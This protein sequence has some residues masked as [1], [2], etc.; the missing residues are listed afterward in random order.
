MKTSARI[1]SALVLA[2]LVALVTTSCSP[3][4]RKAKFLERADRYFTNGQFDQAEIEYKNALAI[5]ALNPVAISR[6]GVIYFEQGR[7]ARCTPYLL[8]GRELRPDDLE[9]RLKLAQLQLGA[10]NAT[11]AR[12]EIDFI[13]SR[14]PTQ[15]EALLLLA[16]MGNTQ[17]QIDEIRQRLQKIAG[18]NESAPLLVA[19]GML[20]L[21]QRNLP[22]AQAAFQK[23][24]TLDP[25]SSAA[26]AALGT[27]YWAQGNLPEADQAL[28]KSAELSPPRSSR[29]LAYAQFKLQTGDPSAARRVLEELT[30]KT[31]DYL[32]AWLALAEMA[33]RERKYDDSLA[34]IAKILVRDDIMPEALLLSSRLRLLKGENDKAVGEL[35]KML[36]IYP[37]AYEVHYQ[38]GLAYLATGSKEKAIASL[39]Q[40]VALAPGY[41]EAVVALANLRTGGGDPIAAV[42]SLKQYLQQHP[43]AAQAWLS[44]AEA[45]RAQGNPDDALGAY[46]ELEKRFPRNPQGPFLTGLMLRQQN[47]NDEARQA[48]NRAIGLAPGYLPAVEQLVDLDLAESHYATAH[49][50]I[51]GLLAANPKLAEAYLLRARI[52]LTQ[53]DRDQAE[54]TLRKTIEL[55]PSLPTSYFLLARLY[56]TAN[57]QAKALASLLQAVAQNPRDVTAKM[58]V[59][60][61]YEQRQDFPAAQKAYEEILGIN[62]GFSPALNNLAYLYSE[63]TSQLDKAYTLAQ[64]ARELLPQDPRAADT[65]GWILFKRGE[66]RRALSLLTESA[67][68]LPTNAEIQFHLG[69]THYMMGEETSARLALDRALQLSKDFPQADEARRRLAILEIDVTKAGNEA[70]AALEKELASRKDDPMVLARLASVY[71][72][73]GVV[74]KAIGAYQ[75]ALQANPANAKI[76]LNLVRIYA[77]RQDNTKAMELAKTARKAAP[78]NPNVAHVLGRL[79]YQSGDY[80]WGAS[81][82]QEAAGKLPNDPEVLYDFARACYSVGRVP[83][84]ET[85]LR[86]AL[87]TGPAFSCLDDAKRFLDMLDCAANPTQASAA[88]KVEQALKANPED[89]P[90]LMAKAALAEH[91]TDPLA[92]RAIYEK[93]LDY[94]KEFSPAKRRLAILLAESSSDERKALEW[95]RQARTA[96]PNDPELAKALGILLYK[97]KDYT[98][99]VNLLKESSRQR[100]SDASLMYYL[101]MAQYGL[102]DRTSAKTSLQRSLDLNLRSDL[103]TE[104]RRTLVEIK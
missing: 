77:A 60:G 30:R 72:R 17:P 13:L 84:A 91:G 66:Y 67:D 81:L 33:A 51:D 7:R 39:N 8:K 21:R 95:A 52:F 16:D 56:F 50:R 103:A 38:L 25:K 100:D 76:L 49:Q 45:Y 12:K 82:L 92:A 62:P 63:H 6:L 53:G 31:P 11:E 24:L 46:R 43:D 65:L 10:G 37:R 36:K 68:D 55:Q 41:T 58:L 79:A 64:K 75:T 98:M 47:K 3:Q 29:R 83:D 2:G 32:P 14:N 20:D 26:Y 97:N 4:A 86:Q 61:I 48:F 35:E 69:L 96:F 74:D 87:Q 19:L 22:T 59:G 99:A 89:L 54:A 70:Q 73:N 23:A 42:A 102:K 88:T 27:L 80:P 78:D 9:V 93:I 34:L 90:A 57:D 1:L 18:A 101:G 71:E 40:A 28:A 104:A 15:A 44:L 94:N 85:A 5:E